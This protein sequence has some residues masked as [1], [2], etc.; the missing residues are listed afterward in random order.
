MARKIL[1][2]GA[3]YTLVDERNKVLTSAG[4]EVVSATNLLEVTNACEEHDFALVVLGQGLN[5][6]EKRRIKSTIRSS[7]KR[8]VPI[9]AL[10]QKS[11]SEADD[12]DRSLAA[13]DGPEALVRAVK[14]MLG[15]KQRAS[16][17]KAAGKH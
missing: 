12:A 6:N 2:V 13:Q 10:Y 15:S 8:G 5:V 3:N 17:H 4:F 1:N 16:K 14:E 7:C 11:V 9:L